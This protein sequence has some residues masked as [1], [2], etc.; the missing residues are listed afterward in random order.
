VALSRPIVFVL[1]ETSGEVSGGNLYNAELLS[2]LQASYDCQRLSV[3]VWQ[4]EPPRAGV[5]LVDSLNLA[6]FE[7]M[8]ASR[9]PGQFFV[10]LVHHLPSLEPGLAADDS[11]LALEGRTLPC[12][13]A[14]LATSQ[15]THSH[16][17]T[18][19]LT[20]PALTVEPVITARPS[21]AREWE[22]P[23]RALMSCNLIPR[24]G[25]LEFLESLARETRPD[26]DY[27]LDIVGRHDLDP[28]YSRRCLA[29]L[30]SSTELGARV[31]LPGESAYEA[32]PA[33]Y[34]KSNLFLSA[35]RMETFGISLQEARYA[36]L[37][38]LAARGGNTANHLKVGVTGELFDDPGALALGFLKRVRSSQELALYFEAAQKARSEIT[39]SGWDDAARRVMSSLEGWFSES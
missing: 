6:E 1:P 20:Q 3:R 11:Q 37:P 28:D 24:K 38:I 35:S 25:V 26:D 9:I 22:G 8:Y 21:P 10:L 13:D 12:F 31:R 18:R 39:G 32:M 19:G 30:A 2:S 33:W 34:E 4:S 14:F 27:Q 5:Y 23:V 36:G 17:R 15:F 29:C 7:A 16:L